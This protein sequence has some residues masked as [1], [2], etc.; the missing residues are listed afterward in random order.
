MTWPCRALTLEPISDTL[1]QSGWLVCGLGG[2]NAIPAAGVSS[3]TGVSAQAANGLAFDCAAD[4]A[5]ASGRAECQG[6][7][8]V[9]SIWHRT[10]EIA[11]SGR[12]GQRAPGSVAQPPSARHQLAQLN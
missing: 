6:L 3:S 8:V 10:R 9:E 2:V 5:G 1:S 7:D 11:V 4:F 12:G